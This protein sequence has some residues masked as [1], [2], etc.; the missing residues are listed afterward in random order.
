MRF[1]FAII[2]SRVARRVIW[3]FFMSTL[4]PIAATAIYSFAYV[5]NLLLEQSYKQL[6]H[7][8][9][10]YGMVVLERLLIVDGRLRELAEGLVISSENPDLVQAGK[11]KIK[12]LKKNLEKQLDKLTLETVPAASLNSEQGLSKSLISSETDPDGVTRVYLRHIISIA[13]DNNAVILVAELNNDFLWGDKDTLPFSTSLCV[14]DDMGK[15]LFCPNSKEK[16]LLENIRVNPEHTAKRKFSWVN[17]NGRNL[18]VAWDLFIKSNFVGQDWKIISSMRESDA[19]FSVHAYSRIFPLVILLSVLT[20]IL[21]SLI[22]VRRIMFPLERLVS[23]TRRL[24]RYE[25]GEPVNVDSKDEFGELGDSF[26][27][28][29]FRLEKQF[30]TLKIL[31][32]IDH[33][34]LSYPDLDVVLTKIFDTAHKIIS[35]DFIVITLLEK[36][37][38]TLGWTHIKE[39]STN[40]PA[41]VEKVKIPD[42]E[43]KRLLALE[44]V[45]FFDLIV[46]PLHCLEPVEKRGVKTVQVCPILLN[47]SLRGMFSLGY[48]ENSTKAIDDSGPARDIIDRLAVA[49]ATADRDEKL[50]RQAHFDFLT[51]LPNRQ[52]F[53]DRL[54]QHI[55]R[56]RRKNEKAAI[57]YIDL[58]RFKNINDSLGHATGD[59]L[60]R[61][62]ADR[63]RGCVRETDTVSRLSGDEFVILMSNVSSP[64]DA[65]NIA[66]HIIAEISK[67]YTLSAREIFIS[68]SVGIAVYPEDGVNNKELLARADTAMYHAKESGRGR[69]MFFEESMNREIVHRIEME[70]AMRHAILRDEFTLYYQPQ[71]E[72]SSGK[73]LAIEALIRW[74]HPELGL[75]LPSQ[76]IPLAEECGLIEQLGEWVL[77][78]ACIQFHAWR[79]NNIAPSRLAVN[80]SSR[81]FMREN[82]I[83]ILDKVINST[84]IE[85][86][87]LELEI[88]ESLL[89]DESINTKAIFDK[90]GL[91]G[92]HLAIDDFGTGYSSLGYLKRFPVHTLK[93]DRAFTRDIPADEQA[94]T[95]TLSII[96]MAH[97]LNMHVVA[98][99]VETVEQFELLQL[100]RCD[101]VQG[102]YFSKAIPAEEM[103]KFLEHQAVIMK[104]N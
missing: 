58:D 60:L 101:S 2:R 32:D 73:V 48:R 54:Q 28:M 42:D 84:R 9:K 103:T 75:V 4:I 96:A 18:A 98:E 15:V 99:G 12:G 86:R 37:D 11:N 95:L 26:N 35:C 46:Q 65:S 45:Q 20:V 25:F 62:V 100:H 94:T 52:L 21:L 38:T 13:K 87:E 66:E 41:Y 71:V 55:L 97:A 3:L 16:T 44:E 7:A 70:T 43:L 91:M 92:V 49:L 23:A 51:G 78:N 61:K 53:N 50:Y 6:Q 90:L 85:P 83:H 82:F 68:A 74:N 47:G 40:K 24:A 29:A 80:I 34:I 64:K 22:Q 104:S 56:A 77:K 27:T 102:N 30:N 76:F 36:S 33:L 67:P 31:S 8:S 93:I 14:L 79:E 59:M 39:V 81:Q 19:L 5:S 63:M 72:L 17:S 89:L 69:F 88:T 10:L 57:L 1:N